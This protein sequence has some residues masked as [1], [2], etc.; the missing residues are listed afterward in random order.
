MY[1]YCADLKCLQC[2]E[3]S[4]EIWLSPNFLIEWKFVVIVIFIVNGCTVLDRFAFLIVILFCTNVFCL[5]NSAW[6]Y[7]K[8]FL[9]HPPYAF[10]ICIWSQ[11]MSWRA[12]IP[13]IS[14]LLGFTTSYALWLLYSKQWEKKQVNQA[15]YFLETT[16]IY[17]FG[18]SFIISLSK[19][20]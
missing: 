10:N 5:S 14:V 6:K 7:L 4:I 3:I 16:I 18:M 20:M 13:G 9:T 8:I 12:H 11:T 15:P 1:I 2:D 17:L 19:Y